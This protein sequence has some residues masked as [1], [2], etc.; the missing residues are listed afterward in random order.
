[1]SDKINSP[2]AAALLAAGLTFGSAAAMGASAP[3]A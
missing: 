3:V 2:L 1:M